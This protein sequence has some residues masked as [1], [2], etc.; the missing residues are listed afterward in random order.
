[1]TGRDQRPAWARSGAGREHGAAS[2]ARA[3]VERDRG[4][5]RVLAGLSKLRAD[6]A[7]EEAE[8]CAAC[9]EVRARDDDPEALC[10]EHLAH[11]MG[12]HSSWDAIRER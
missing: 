5:E 1:M 6:A 8:V 10:E 12:M 7:Y 9:T 4:D 2:A 3:A 11:A